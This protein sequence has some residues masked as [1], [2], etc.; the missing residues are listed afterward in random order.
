MENNE[1][2]GIIIEEM[3]KK[4]R[5]DKNWSY[6]DVSYHLNDTNI[7][8]ENI[9]K[10]ESGL[11]YPDLDMMYKLSEL[12]SVP[13][14]DLVKAKEFSYETLRSSFSVTLIKWINYFF[15]ISFKISMVLVTIFYFVAAILKLAIFY[16]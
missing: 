4:L 13:V 10:M 6:N 9:K 14:E 7:M 8:P 11:E 5:E 1:E 16:S 12:Y 2:N 3:L 15:G